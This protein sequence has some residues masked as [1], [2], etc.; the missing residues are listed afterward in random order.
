MHR[1]GRDEQEVV[2]RL[3]H[4]PLLGDEPEVDRAEEAEEPALDAGLLLDLA[5][6]GV[7]GSLARLEMSL[8][9]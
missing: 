5:D 9:Q 6:R 2:H 4:A 7:L 8:G 1:I 3:V